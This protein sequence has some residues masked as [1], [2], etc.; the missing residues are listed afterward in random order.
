MKSLEPPGLDIM[1]ST[2]QCILHVLFSGVDQLFNMVT[3]RNCY[4]QQ[5]KKL[6]IQ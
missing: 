4:E 5:S 3:V 6:L 1:E 2:D